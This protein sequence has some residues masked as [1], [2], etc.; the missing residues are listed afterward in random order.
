VF[1]KRWRY[2]ASKINVRVYY[3]DDLTPI[4]EA[5]CRE[6]KEALSG[7]TSCPSCCRL[8]SATL[9]RLRAPVRKR[10]PKFALDVMDGQFVPNI[11]LRSAPNSALRGRIE[12]KVSRRI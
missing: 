11:H 6:T 2:T 3:R 1:G 7:S 8:T 5:P 10:A 4:K 12:G 9:R